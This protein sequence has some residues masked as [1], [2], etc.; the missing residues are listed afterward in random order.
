MNYVRNS[1]LK[2]RIF[3][4]LC[5][6]MGSEFEVL[7][8][9]FNVWCLSRGKALN[10]VLALC[11]KLAVFLREHQY[12]HADCFEKSEFILVLAYMADIFEALNH[13]IQQMQGGGV[14]IIEAEEH[15]RAFQKKIKLWKRRTENDNFANFSLLDG[16]ISEIEDVPRNGNISVPPKLT[17]AISLHLDELT[18]SLDGYFLNMESYPA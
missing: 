10:R 5:N 7:L 3:K 4:E 1:A 16:C 15:L 13:L 9:C 14:N 6:E 12:C 11:V 8:Y 18:T 17:Q 2:H